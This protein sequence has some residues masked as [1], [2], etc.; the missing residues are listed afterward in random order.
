MRIRILSSGTSP[1]ARWIVSRIRGWSPARGRSCF[2]LWG[3]LAGQNRVPDPPAR[4]VTHRL[5][6]GDIE[7][8]VDSGK[9]FFGAEGLREEVVGSEAEG[10][11]PVGIL[12]LC[13]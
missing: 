9:E 10:G 6:S 5:G 12:A 1:R 11:F 8:F 7:E 13:C 2:G 4:T 3:V